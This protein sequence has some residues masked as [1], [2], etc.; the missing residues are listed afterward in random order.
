M[1]IIELLSEND[2]ASQV[3]ANTQ[4]M[5][6]AFQSGQMAPKQFAPGEISL[7]QIFSH[8]KFR[9]TV[10]AMHKKYPSNRDQAQRAA[11]EV[12]KGLIRSGK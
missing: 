4:A 10:Q 3:S 11:E 2:L 1:K 5:G 12:I 7:S 6:Q 9:E 8:P